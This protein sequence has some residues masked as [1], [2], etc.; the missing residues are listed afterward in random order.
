VPRSRDLPKI[1]ESS[2]CRNCHRPQTC[3]QNFGVIKESAFARC[4]FEPALDCMPRLEQTFRVTS[5]TFAK[6]F[7]QAL[8]V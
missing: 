1:S 5:L 6:P 4:Q 7:L 3:C 2:R 8:S